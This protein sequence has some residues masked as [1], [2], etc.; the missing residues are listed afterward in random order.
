[1]ILSL[2]GR[3]ASSFLVTEARTIMAETF[4]FNADIQQLMSCSDGSNQVDLPSGIIRI[5][6]ATDRVFVVRLQICGT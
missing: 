4:A 5:S 1:M 3:G 2:A 6:L